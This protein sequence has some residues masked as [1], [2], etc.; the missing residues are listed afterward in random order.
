MAACEHLLLIVFSSLLARYHPF[1]V[2]LRLIEKM[3][4]ATRGKSRKM[5]NDLNPS[6][7]KQPRIGVGMAKAISHSIFSFLLDL[8]S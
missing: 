8:L 2:M 3:S 1:P 6:P 7:V 5:T 4:K